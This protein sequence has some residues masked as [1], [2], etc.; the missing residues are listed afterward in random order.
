MYINIL[1]ASRRQ[2]AIE[3]FRRLNFRARLSRSFSNNGRLASFAAPP[4][5]ARRARGL[6]DIPVTRIVGS[7]GRSSDFDRDFRPLKKHLRDRWVRSFLHLE[8][9]AWEPILVHKVGEDYFVE[10]GHHRV[11]V[12][13]YAGLAFIQAEV[14]EYSSAPPAQTHPAGAVP[15]RPG[16]SRAG[17]AACHCEARPA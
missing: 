8:T 17:R 1:P 12:A 6:Q 10:D 9:D 7:L 4:N 5:P 13:R 14:W 16:S 11:S 15:A 2:L 3:A